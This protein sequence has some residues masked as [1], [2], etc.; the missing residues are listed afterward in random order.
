MSIRTTVTLEED[1][2]QRLKSE[3]KARGTPFRETLNDI[4]RS[5]LIHAHAKPPATP[6][7]IQTF[8]FGVRP[9][10][11]YDNTEQLLE[12]GEGEEHR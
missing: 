5:G 4:I 2:Y 6:F 12:L 3:S 7:Q 9:G 11:S 8:P 10:I 1:V